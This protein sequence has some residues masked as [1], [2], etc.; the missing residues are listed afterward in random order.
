MSQIADLCDQIVERLSALGSPIAKLLQPGITESLIQEIQASLPFVFPDAAVEMYKWR[1]GTEPVE[2][3]TLFPG[4]GFDTIAESVERYKILATPNDGIWNDHWFP[5]F[6]SSDIS[7]IGIVCDDQPSAD[8]EI[9][10]YEYMLGDEVEFESLEAMLK[11]VLKAFDTGVYYLD[12][13]GLLEVGESTYDDQG[14]LINV[15]MSK[16]NEIARHFNPGL[17]RYER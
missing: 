13:Q 10:T 2:G 11:T 17:K 6:S 8:G 1:N 15:D 12:D 5:L 9:V 7:S 3:S 16:F 4:W 14:R